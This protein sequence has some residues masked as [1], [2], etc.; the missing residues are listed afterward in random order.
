ML[1]ESEDSSDEVFSANDVDDESEREEFRNDM[2][3]RVT[4][5]IRLIF[6]Q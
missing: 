2:A 4:C 6:R 5:K 3:V 1:Y